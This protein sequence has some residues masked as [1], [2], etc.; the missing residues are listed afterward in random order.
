MKLEHL[1][2]DAFKRF[3]DFHLPFQDGEGPPKR[4]TVLI[5]ENGTGKT[6]LLQA[7]ALAAAGGGRLASLVDSAW[8]ATAEDRR[9]AR[10]DKDMG[11]HIIGRFR[12]AGLG[13]GQADGQADGI[14]SDVMG[15]RSS[16]RGTSF[17][18]RTRSPDR[19]AVGGGDPLSAARDLD[20]PRLFVIG[21]GTNRFLPNSFGDIIPPGY[22]VDRLKPLFPGTEG[23]GSSLISLRFIDHFAADRERRL[24][25]VKIL[26]GVMRSLGLFEEL[27]DIELRGQGGARAAGDLLVGNRFGIRMGRERVKLPALSLS[28]GFQST[29]AWVADL[30]GHLLLD[31]QEDPATA[32]GLV[33]VDEID[34]YLHP[35][36]Q[37]RLIRALKRTFPRLQFV[38]TTHSPLVLCGIDPSEDQVVRLVK[39]PATGDVRAEVNTGEDPRLLTGGALLHEYFGIDDIH[40][41]ADHRLLREYVHLAANPWRTRQEDQRLDRW[42]RELRAR[43][44]TFRAQRTAMERASHRV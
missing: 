39:D 10:A 25:F 16:L 15:G 17:L 28:H 33:L 43:G 41:D 37:V 14:V 3:R 18:W 1:H 12:C 24:R 11:L 34:L 9:E 5:G 26:Q 36:R 40:P 27:S 2:I 42:E 20:Q 35:P 23:F 32:E 8:L 6:A 22:S 19:V 31:G 7:I 44:I 4:V 29:L 21:Y 30:V 13:S 38:V